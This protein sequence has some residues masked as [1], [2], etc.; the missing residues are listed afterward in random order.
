MPGPLAGIKVVDVSAIL[1]GPLATMMLADQGAEVV[2]VEP[3]GIG[4]LMRIGPFRSGGLC[5]FFANANRGKRSIALD[6][7]QDRGREVL[8]RLVREAD[9]FVQNFR[10]GVAERLGL[11]YDDL[12]Q[13][14]P[15]LVMTSITPFGQDGPYSQYQGEEIV[16]YA[17][18][19]IMSVSGIQ[20]REP[21]KHGGFQAQYEGGLNGAAATAMVTLSSS[22][23]ATE[24]SGPPSG[25]FRSPP[26]IAA[27][28]KR[29]I[30]M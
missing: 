23:Y 5:A 1:S 4:D 22:K 19:M 9:V 11:G 16:S 15:G 20:G 7:R 6:L 12:Q 29:H 21:L 24:R 10:K 2:K 28:G 18:G 25:I 3:L 17:M 30:G 13:I 14:N 27:S 8:L 26:P